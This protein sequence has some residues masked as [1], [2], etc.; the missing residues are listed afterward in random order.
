MMKKI[1]FLLVAL[2]AIACSQDELSPANDRLP[3]PA[4]HGDEGEEVPEPEQPQE[5]VGE[6]LTLSAT[7]DSEDDDTRAAADDEGAFTW[8]E[9]DKLSVWIVKAGSAGKFASFTITS[10]AGTNQANFEGTVETG[11][12]IGDLAVFAPSISTYSYD[13]SSLSLTLPASFAA[14]TTVPMVMCGNVTDGLHAHLRHCLGIMK[15]NLSNLPEGISGF[16]LTSTERNLCGSATVASP[17]GETPVGTLP[18]GT[19]SNSVTVTFSAAAEG[20]SRTVWVP[21][22]AATYNNL[23]FT[24]LEGSTPIWRRTNTAQNIVAR[25]SLVKFDLAVPASSLIGWQNTALTDV[26]ITYKTKET[27]LGA[28]ISGASNTY[29]F[30]CECEVP[31][32]AAALVSAYNTAHS[33]SYTLLPAASY[34]LGA[35]SFSS[36]SLSGMASLS[37][38]R[39]GLTAD[40]EYLLPISLGQA[41][42][43]ENNFGRYRKSKTVKYIHVTNPKYVFEEIQPTN[44]KIAFCNNEDRKSNVWSKNMF[45]RN[46]STM[47]ASFWKFYDQSEGDTKGQ[48]RPKCHLDAS[49]TLVVDDFRYPGGKNISD[50]TTNDGWNPV[51]NGGTYPAILQYY[52]N[53]TTC[54][55]SY[56]RTSL[57]GT[58]VVPVQYP[59]CDGVRKYD[60][61]VVVIDL[62]ENVN[63][64]KV[65]IEKAK[66]SVNYL[67]LKKMT[68]FMSDNFTFTTANQY[69]VGSSDW[70]AA[71]DNYDNVNAG[72]TWRKMMVWKDIPKGNS[73]D[74][75]PCT[76]KQVHADTLNTAAAWGRY[77]KLAF[78]DSWRSGDFPIEVAE[79]YLWKLVSIDGVPVPGKSAQ[80]NEDLP[81]DVYSW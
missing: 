3:L 60:K 48:I 15:F 75:L 39:T 46:S 69:T 47:Y 70:L 53:S 2:S 13:G 43:G 59:C 21:V 41:K 81:T 78:Q 24:L 68:L 28:S 25:N 22:P 17:R 30:T 79:F 67:D 51:G 63:I 54:E 6:K 57:N 20:T 45:D 58:R 50:V 16:Q 32:N 42:Q 4:V 31:E 76:E 29:T 61:L 33:K 9:G 23:S 73:T 64:G 65:G 80:S 66:G 71:I 52:S 5:P 18:S 7:I 55:Y 11:Y 36:G 27:T 72:N 37:L 8:S 12:S 38:S 56:G 49:H 19:S 62:G 74:G 40:T 34:E 77:I 1:L 14:G 10:G 26:E 44:W 35:L